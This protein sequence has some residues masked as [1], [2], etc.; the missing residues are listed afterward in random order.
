MASKMDL[1][2]AMESAMNDLKRLPG[3]GC[4][5]HLHSCCLYQ[6]HLNPGY[7]AEW[8]CR[9]L[10]KWE[11]AFDDFLER[12]EVFNVSQDAVAGLWLKTFERMAREKFE[13]SEYEY[14]SG[15]ELPSC[16]Y[17]HNNLCLCRLP[18]CEGRCRHFKILGE[19]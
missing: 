6:E 5:H 2:F 18:S 19:D 12:A 11:K 14:S 7:M 8:R 10:F 17:A 3:T 13:C 4:K 16:R 15:T 9:V 1:L